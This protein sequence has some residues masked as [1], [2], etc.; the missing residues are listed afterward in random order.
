MKNEDTELCHTSPAGP[1]AAAMPG[2]CCSSRARIW[3][4]LR[5]GERRPWTSKA[6]SPTILSLGHGSLLAARKA[7]DRHSI[8]RD[9]HSIPME[10]PREP[11]TGQDEVR[12]CRGG[13]R[14]R[15]RHGGV[16]GGIPARHSHCVTRPGR[17]DKSRRCRGAAGGAARTHR[18][19][20]AGAARAGQGHEGHRGAG[21]KAQLALEPPFAPPGASPPA[22]PRIDTKSWDFSP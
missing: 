7:R 22:Q 9:R 19:S 21:E 11:G 17:Q 6:S 5:A 14:S 3:E 4:A 2:S 15:T 18:A 12:G 16:C 1:G 20:R 8:R 13:D 10:N